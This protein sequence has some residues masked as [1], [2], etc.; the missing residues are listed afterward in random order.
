MKK[1]EA[2]KP[3]RDLWLPDKTKFKDSGGRYITQ[4]L[5]LENG[6]N[7]DFAVYTLTDADKEYNGVVYK[8]LRK[9]YLQ[10]ADPTEY[11]FAVKYL[12]GWEHWKRIVNNSLM[13]AQIEEWREELEVKLRAMGVASVI[14]SSYDSFNAAKWVADGGWRGL[15]G[16]PSKAEKERDKKIRERVVGEVE[17]DASRIVDFLKRKDAS[18]G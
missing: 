3:E 17:D 2:K 4:S 15:R 10:E 18:D 16:R 14:L 12:W 7:T 6:Y 11:N 9:L 5:F 13:T 1:E 8:S